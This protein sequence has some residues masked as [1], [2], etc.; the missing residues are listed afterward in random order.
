MITV[1]NL[2]VT[3][4]EFSL[5]DVSFE[6]S[7]GSY[8]VLMGKTGSGKT[9]ILECICGLRTL[10]SGRIFL[11]GREVTN[12]KPGERGIGY[13]PQDG[14]LFTTMTVREHL[15]LA[16]S[17]RSWRPKD[18]SRRVEELADLLGIDNLLERKPE[19]LSGGE[20]QRVALGRALSFHPE[21]LC[22]DEP[23][24]ALDDQTHEEMCEL[25]ESV[26][27]QTGVTTLHVTHSRSEME[28]LANQLYVVKDGTIHQFSSD[29]EDHE[30]PVK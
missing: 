15:T 24:I 8:G 30:P 16:L 1:R 9:T 2:S 23:L 28:R 26:R 27:Y 19:G 7:T 29:N 6:I 17:I 14:A 18:V 10:Y 13:L 22:L 4:G 3:V 11:M 5:H 12:L 21:I 25:L 20:I